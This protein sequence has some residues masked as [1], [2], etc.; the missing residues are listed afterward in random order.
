[1][2][3]RQGEALHSRI[4][5]AQVAGEFPQHAPQAEEQRFG[6]ADLEL[7]FKKRFVSGR[8]LVHG[9]RVGRRPHEPIEVRADLGTE[10]P[11]DAVPGQLDEQADRADAGEMHLMGDVRREA[12]LRNRQLPYALTQR[13]PGRNGDANSC[14]SEQGCA[15]ERGADAQPIGVM[16]L[17]QL[18]FEAFDQTAKTAEQFEARADFQPQM[19]G[20]RMAHLSRNLADDHGAAELIGPRG[21]ALERSFL[22]LHVALDH[23]DP[24]LYGQ[25]RSVTHP[26]LQAGALGGGVAADHPASAA[27]ARCDDC[28]GAFRGGAH[29]FERQL[30]QSNAEPQHIWK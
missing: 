9:T 18:P 11:R 21:Q 4:A 24:G 6:A 20:A 3:Q 19:R 1:M 14:A 27:L 8:Q 10:A 30:R 26:G 13:F 5:R 23:H 17:L 22:R 29:R 7:E 15:F 28:R 2:H 12:Q 25:R 16:Q